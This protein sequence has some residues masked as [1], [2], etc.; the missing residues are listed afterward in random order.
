MFLKLRY[1]PVLTLL[2]FSLGCTSQSERQEA[3]EQGGLVAVTVVVDESL[4]SGS[5]A[6][7]IAEPTAPAVAT[8]DNAYPAPVDS[9][10]Q[11]N[12]P[13]PGAAT[14]VPTSTPPAEELV[15]PPLPV[16]TEGK[17]AII[18]RLIHAEHGSPGSNLIL[19]LGTRVEAEPGPGYLISTM[20]NSSPHAESNAGGYFTISD[21][22]PGTYA[23]VIGSLVGSRI[24]QNPESGEEYWVDIVAGE[25]ADIGEVYFTFP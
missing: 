20:R 22:E 16:P 21:V 10:R 19:Y 12:T 14:Q 1:I 13:Y 3:T 25:V 23:L 9:L 8:T 11:P 4:S 17:G 24:L 6:S 5:S 15:Q 2:I 7:E 18:G